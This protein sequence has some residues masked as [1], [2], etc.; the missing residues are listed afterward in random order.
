MT[1][2][3]HQYELMQWAFAVRKKYPELRMLHHIPNG[4]TRDPVEAK[5]LLRAG[6]K[7]G[8]PDLSLPVARRGFHGLYIELKRENGI[9]SAEQKWW[10]EE[11]TAQRYLAR[12]CFG[13]REA[14]KLLEWY[15][16]KEESR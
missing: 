13:C 4:G 9:V 2:F 8:V 12:V 16:Q 1:E 7:K 14:A 5:N 10:I 11:L 6:V 15:L 3:Q